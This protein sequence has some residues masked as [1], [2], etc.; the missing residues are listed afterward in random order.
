MKTACALVLVAAIPALVGCAGG[1]SS[2]SQTDD[3]TA[4]Q[5]VAIGDFNNSALQDGW[6]DLQSK[7]NGEFYDVCGDTFCE[8]DYANLVGLSMNCAVTS[9]RGDVHDCAWTFSG[10][11]QMVNPETAAIA[12]DKPT[13]QCHFKAKTTA[14]KLVT[15]LSSSSDA[16]HEVL[17]GGTVSIYDGLVDCFQH[18]IGATPVPYVDDPAPKYVEPIDYYKSSSSQTK[19]RN[20]QAALKNGFDNI[21]GDT[22]CGGDFGDLQSLDFICSVTKST[23]NVKSCAWIFGGSYLGVNP[24]TG[25]VGPTT[26]SWTC[27]VPVKGTIGQLISTLGSSPGAIQQPLPGETTSAY[28]A[29]GNNCLP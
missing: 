9:I 4:T 6:Y 19:W 23:G 28:D 27:P 25:A 11:N 20:T 3:S 17:P 5:Y 7:L 22:F 16:I 21:C 13:F 2:D 14:S 26:D 1:D 10:S 29:I 18:P 12:V 24:K 8:G 15:L